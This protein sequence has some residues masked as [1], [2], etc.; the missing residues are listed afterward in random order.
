[1]KA[2]R[3]TR[4]VKRVEW[5]S[6]DVMTGTMAT[7]T[8]DSSAA[9]DRAMPV[10]QLFMLVLCLVALLGVVVQNAFRLDPEIELVLQWADTLI[11]VGFAVDFL[12]SLYRAPNRTRYFFTWG[13]LDLLSS[14]PMLDV[15]RWGRLARVARIAR[16]LRGI[17][18][19]RRLTA[20]V[21]QQRSE[22]T[23]LAAALFALVILTASSTAILHF[24][25]RPES[26]IRTANDAIWWAFTTITTVGYGDRFPVTTGGRVVAALLMTAGVGLFGAFSAALAAWFL[27]PE[28]KATDAE[29]S[30]L[31]EE[32]AAL[33]R[34]V[35]ELAQKNDP[36][37]PAGP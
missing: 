37:R 29:I 25:T 19:A 2:P 27:A 34:A 30:G 32:L 18:A 5:R 33:R 35:E 6:E 20:L 10:Y 11:C 21:L 36:S 22:S 16:V 8:D 26:N 24:E 12:L 4:G 17:R 28:D 31:R 23:F 1:M 15:G 7:R 14:I 3:H 9:S 13:W